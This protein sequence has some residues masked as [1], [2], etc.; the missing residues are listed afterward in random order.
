MCIS[1]VSGLDRISSPGRTV[2]EEW[3]DCLRL[4]PLGLCIKELGEAVLLALVRRRDL[5][6]IVLKHSLVKAHDE[7]AANISLGAV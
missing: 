3:G 2:V 6:H 7:L 1:R 5:L 4:R